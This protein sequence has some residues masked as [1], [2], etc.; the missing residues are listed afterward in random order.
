MLAFYK[1]KYECVGKINAFI[2]K[3][4]NRILKK[5]YN[6]QATN[7][8]RRRIAIAGQGCNVQTN[9]RAQRCGHAIR[10]E[11]VYVR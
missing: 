11:I 8:C 6:G 4:Y 5:R 9:D 2:Y 10:G 7:Y 3:K 1:K